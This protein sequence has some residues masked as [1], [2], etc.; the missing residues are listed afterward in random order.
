M[1][2]SNF[3]L[4]NTLSLPQKPPY[5]FPESLVRV[6][7]SP[8]NWSSSSS[9]MG[10]V[11][12]SCEEY[13]LYADLQS[14]VTAAKQPSQSAA[15]LAN[16]QGTPAAW[17]GACLGYHTLQGRRILRYPTE[18]KEQVSPCNLDRWEPL[19]PHVTPGGCAGRDACTLSFVHIKIL[20]N[21]TAKNT[22]DKK[23][24]LFTIQ[25]LTVSK[26]REHRRGHPKEV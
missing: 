14:Q 25:R 16:P 19:D 3:R 11:P 9:G 2:L 18:L 10:R 23:S 4:S 22:G 1:T 8:D 17:A 21:Q 12:T 5:N 15:G 26:Q 7:R 20:L 13:L 24:V 6:L